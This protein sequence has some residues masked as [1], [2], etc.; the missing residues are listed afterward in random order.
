MRNLSSR[1]HIQYS[2]HINY[3]LIAF[4]CHEFICA[5]KGYTALFL[6]LVSVSFLEQTSSIEYNFLPLSNPVVD[7]CV[8]AGPL[9]TSARVNN[10]L[11]TVK[12]LC[13]TLCYES[14]SRN[15]SNNTK[16]SFNVYFK[17]SHNGAV[18][19]SR[20]IKTLS[21][22]GRGLCAAFYA[23]ECIII[24]TANKKEQHSGENSAIPHPLVA[25][26][27]VSILVNRG[28]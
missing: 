27:F 5:H 19:V 9:L 3:T 11:F 2:G 10:K 24:K 15:S 17:R 12:L 25:G 4:T 7:V 14:S 22:S 13:C 20:T 21:K 26:V 16:L 6:R 23:N 8:G 18:Q 28:H 1:E